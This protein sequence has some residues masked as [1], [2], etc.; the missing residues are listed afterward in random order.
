[1]ADKT[2]QAPVYNCIS[3][4]A[5]LHFDPPTGKLK[6]DYCDSLYTPEEIEEHFKNKESE[7]AAQRTDEEFKS[8]SCSSCGAELLADQNTAVI[9]CPYCGNNTI[10][11]AQFASNIRPD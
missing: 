9:L 2:N 6:C 4:G 1:M 7:E 8:Y 3:C 11:T 10:A 5:P